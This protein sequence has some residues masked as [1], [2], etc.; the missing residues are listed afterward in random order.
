M[1]SICLFYYLGCHK[2]SIVVIVSPLTALMM[3]QKRV[4]SQKGLTVEYVG[5]ELDNLEAIMKGKIQLVYVSPESLMGNEKIRKMFLNSVYVQNLVA[6]VVDE[7]HC[8]K[9]W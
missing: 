1:F 2:K 5:E 9:L 4:L 3:D 6:F 7:A 8:V